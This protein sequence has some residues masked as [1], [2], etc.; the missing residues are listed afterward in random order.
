[1]GDGERRGSEGRGTSGGGGTSPAQLLEPIPDEPPFR[2][3]LA[4]K[5]NREETQEEEMEEEVD[6]T[7][8]PPA[9]H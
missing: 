7:Q 8:E 2:P 1:V 6:G 9:K 5:R 4:S 3:R